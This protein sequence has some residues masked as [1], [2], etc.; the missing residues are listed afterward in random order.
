MGIRLLKVR[1]NFFKSFRCGV[2][3]I[4][5]SYD[6]PG[7]KNSQYIARLNL[8]QSSMNLAY[9]I[10]NLMTVYINLHKLSN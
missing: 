7:T 2:A 6:K 10:Y 9:F 4:D 3:N 1:G 5:T 8:I